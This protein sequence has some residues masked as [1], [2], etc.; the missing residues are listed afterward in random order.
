MLNDFF[1]K[2]TNDLKT[3]I[4][5]GFNRM[6]S[7]ATQHVKHTIYFKPNCL[8]ELSQK[9]DIYWPLNSYDLIP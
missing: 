6:E 9:E 2:E 7:Y 1:F 3:W 4:T 8:V 5:F